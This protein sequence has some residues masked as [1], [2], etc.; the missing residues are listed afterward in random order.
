MTDSDHRYA[1]TFMAKISLIKTL[2]RNACDY[3]R[4]FRHYADLARKH[5]SSTY[6]RIADDCAVQAHKA[7]QNARGWL[8][9][10]RVETER[11]KS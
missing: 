7:R 9:G 3:D 4:Q 1:H 6:R 2:R 8:Q 11:Y 5:G 10:L